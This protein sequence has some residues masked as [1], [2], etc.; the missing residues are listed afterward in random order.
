MEK[1]QRRTNKYLLLV[2]ILIAVF[3]LPGC[4]T[5][6]TNNSE[7]ANIQ[8]DEDGYM[9]ETY[10]MRRDEL[11]LT[12]A[13]KPLLP[14]FGSG[15]TDTN[16]D[17]SE[18][19]EINYNP[20]DYQEDFTEPETNTSTNTNNNTNT[21]TNTNRTIRPT[22]RPTTTPTP[23]G[24]RPSGTDSSTITIT[25][26]PGKGGT[27]EGEKKGKTLVKSGISKGSKITPPDATREGYTLTSWEGSDGKSI[28]PGE[29]GTVNKTATYTAQWEKNK[30]TVIKRKVTFDYA[31]GEVEEKEREID[32]GSTY[33][34]LPIPFYKGNHFLG[35]YTDDGNKV[36]ANTKVSTDH[37]IHAK[38]DDWYSL[39]SKA[40]KNTPKEKCLI[41]DADDACTEFV[42][43]CVATAVV[44]DTQEF[45]FVVVF[46]DNTEDAY[47]TATEQYSGKKIIALSNNALST[48]D[49]YEYLLYQ[50]VL[51]NKLHGKLEYQDAEKDMQLK[52]TF[53]DK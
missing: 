24:R 7:V 26:N 35:W 5:R 22:T 50:I 44:D 36:E 32:D 15:E 17:F 20:E 29:K 19:E 53:T 2:L 25:F 27:I 21:S 33:G 23:S 34:T 38:W 18:G 11:G 46:S 6:I 12:T 47:R 3:V 52:A 10:Q 16:D 30:P 49:E 4:R 31:G 51:F 45:D 42:E 14:N 9:S 28:A 41:I 40:K 43:G 48:E 37:T 39:Y 8:Y 1:K 13:E